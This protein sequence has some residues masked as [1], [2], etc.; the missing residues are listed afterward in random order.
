MLSRSGLEAFGLAALS[1]LLVAC[2]ALALA[3]AGAAGEPE[4]A[5]GLVQALVAREQSLQ[6]LRGYLLDRSYISPWAATARGPVVRTVGVGGEAAHAGTPAPPEPEERTYGLSF[7]EFVLGPAC[8]RYDVLLLRANEEKLWEIG[9]AF[10]LSMAAGG[11]V[12][13][14]Q[15]RMEKPRFER[16][17][18]LQREGKLEFRRGSPQGSVGVTVQGGGQ[19]QG[20]ALE[21]PP[22]ADLL[23]GMARPTL[24]HALQAAADAVQVRGPEKRGE[25]EEY[26]L[27]ARL[28]DPVSEWQ[29]WVCPTWGYAPTEITQ[30][31]D[32]AQETNLPLGTQR[33]ARRW[34][35]SDFR[36]LAEDL[37]LPHKVVFFEFFY[38]PH[39]GEG[40]TPLGRIH[41]ITLYGL[42]ANTSPDPATWEMPREQ[43]LATEDEL[44]ALQ[45]TFPA[46]GE[47]PGWLTEAAE[48]AADPEMPAP[49]QDLL[50]WVP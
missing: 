17:V 33:L 6:D 37:W 7:G 29:V 18:I 26:L 19:E 23:F 32:P 43:F 20:S 13:G 30:Q 27:T 40:H 48:Y 16:V 28:G 46:L 38:S 39:I 34:I 41:E 31:Q 14:G 11:G 35:F 22:L 2:G 44:A 49:P 15:P 21:Q 12:N 4:T 5:A 1:L 25:Q 47:H 10:S 36:Q 24:G 9:G 8:S 45:A 3:S 42:E 50:N